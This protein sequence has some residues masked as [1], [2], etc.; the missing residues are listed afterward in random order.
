M[1]GIKEPAVQELVSAVVVLKEGQSTEVSEEG[2]RRFVES[3]VDADY[4]RVREKVIFHS[5]F[6][7]DDSIKTLASFAGLSMH[8]GKSNI[9]LARAFQGR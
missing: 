2:I 8:F 6:Y 5:F 4:K 1:F 7:K 3:K 9:C